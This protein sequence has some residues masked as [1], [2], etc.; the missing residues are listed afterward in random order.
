MV[1][2][3]AETC[4]VHFA[5]KL[6]SFY[7]CEFVGTITVCIQIMYGSWT[8]CTLIMF[9]SIMHKFGIIQQKFLCCRNNK[10][11]G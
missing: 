2:W 10:G 8:K 6:I 7:F 5:Y 3:L 11:V 1:K 9:D 4:I